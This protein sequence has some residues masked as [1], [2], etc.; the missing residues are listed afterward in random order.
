MAVWN[1]EWMHSNLYTNALNVLYLS[2][3]CA[4]LLLWLRRRNQAPLFW[5]AVFAISPVMWSSVYAL[6]LPLPNNLTDFVLQPLFALRN[7]ALWYLLLNLMDLSGHRKLVHWA[8]RLAVVSVAAAFLD[9]CLTFVQPV[10]VRFEVL[11]WVDAI[12]TLITT[13]CEA[14]ALVL[15]SAG[16]RQRLDWQRW[17]LALSAFT[18]QMLIVVIA[19]AQQGQRFTHWTLAQRLSR[20]IFFVGGVYFTAQ[21]VADTILFLSILYAIYRYLQEQQS[22]KAMLEQ[23]LRSA[24]ELQK[25]LIPDDLPALPG[26][27]MSSSYRPAREVGGD[28]FQIIPVEGATLIILG[29]VSGKGLRAAMAVSLIVGALRTLADTTTRPSEILAGLNRRLC[30]RLQDGF[31]TCLAL[32]LEDCGSCTIASAGHPSPF[33]NGGE[34]DLPGAL[35]LGIALD[36]IYG[37][38]TV[39]MRP[40]DRFALY[41]DGLLEARTRSGELFSFD[42]L[43]DLFASPT[44][45]VKASE[46]AIAFGQDDDITVLTFTRTA[47]ADA[48]LQRAT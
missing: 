34:V 25:I 42:R 27:R 31:T 38:T 32:R 23:E 46:T 16:L 10:W 28:F 18:S 11:A 29:D 40:G 47:Q 26:Y 22:R 14:Y 21:S 35:P 24:R 8:N 41:T 6:H 12:L 39:A 15:V 19:A 45:A 44:D 7:V 48:E 36:T 13:A 1:Y 20:P 17:V 5:F 2:V 37:E 30:G 43:R 3:G 4:A 33:L 9:G